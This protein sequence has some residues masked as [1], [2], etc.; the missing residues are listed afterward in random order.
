MAFKIKDTEAKVLLTKYGKVDVENPKQDILEKL[1][2]DGSIYV[3]KVE[4]T[5]ET[6]KIEAQKEEPKEDKTKK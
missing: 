1:Y 3:E 5:K 4:D 6:K 2:D